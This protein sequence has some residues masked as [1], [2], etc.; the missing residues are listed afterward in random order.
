MPVLAAAILMDLEVQ[1]L[2]AQYSV[3][4]ALAALSSVGAL[5]LRVHL[6]LLLLA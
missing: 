1:L 4:T 6:L 3:L 2:G 5:C